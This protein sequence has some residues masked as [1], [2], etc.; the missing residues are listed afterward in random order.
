MM[1]RRTAHWH[2]YKVMRIDIL[3]LKYLVKKIEEY[4]TARNVG[5]KHASGEYI[6]FVDGDDYLEVGAVK[7]VCIRM[8]EN[9][10]D[11]LVWNYYFEER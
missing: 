2:Y 10:L 8:Q 5:I 9:N 1:V 6:M 4:Q 7:D 11:M 3:I